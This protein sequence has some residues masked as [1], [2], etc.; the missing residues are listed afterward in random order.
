MFWRYVISFIKINFSQLAFSFFRGGSD[1][2]KLLFNIILKY[3]EEHAIEKLNTKL[4]YHGK[5]NHIPLN[6]TD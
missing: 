3:M 1:I 4:F 6:F 5:L 2:I